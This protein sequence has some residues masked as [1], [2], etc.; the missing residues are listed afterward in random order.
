MTEKETQFRCM[1]TRTRPPLY[2]RHFVW[3]A[4]FY[5]KKTTICSL[6][7]IISVCPNNSNCYVS[8][9]S[10]CSSM[11]D[12]YPC[13][14]CFQTSP[15]TETC[16]IRSFVPAQPPVRVFSSSLAAHSIFRIRW[17]RPLKGSWSAFSRI[18][19]REGS[20]VWVY[21]STALRAHS[22][23]VGSPASSI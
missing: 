16:Y 12:V 8:G 19:S 6:F 17:S 1:P 13:R 7:K 10:N 20:S 22:A 11:A 2:G 9:I 5:Q 14:C 4:E 18:V 23:G 15:A 3:Q 21:R